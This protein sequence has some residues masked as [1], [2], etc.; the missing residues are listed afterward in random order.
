MRAYWEKELPRFERLLQHFPDQLKDMWITVRRV[1]RPERFETK[2]VVQL[3]TQTL[4]VE[5]DAESWMES[6]DKAADTLGLRIKRHK[7]KLRGEWALRRRRRR[8]EELSTAGPQLA[9]D[10]KQDRRQEFFALLG[11]WLGQLKHQVR[12]ELRLLELEGEIRRNEWTA[13]DIVDEVLVRAWEKFASQHDHA[14]LDVWIMTILHEIFDEIVSRGY[15]VSL[16]TPLSRPAEPLEEDSY[17]SF[18]LDHELATLA[19]VLPDGEDTAT[20]DTFERE[21]QRRRLE[22]T[23]AKLDPRGRQAFVQHVTE[24]FD[25]AEIALMQDREEEEV[26]ADIEAGHAALRREVNSSRHDNR[27]SVN[28]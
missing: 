23:L 16:N 14:T 15:Q 1:R 2:V 27:R 25:P 3:P 5:K 10:R 20:W 13:E 9:R 21:E 18:F 12:R 7:E 26:V 8:G 17:S 11:P 24:G 6:F 28:A 22:H 19:D 4:A